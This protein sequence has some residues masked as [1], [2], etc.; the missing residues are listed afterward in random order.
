M[1]FD[2][3]SDYQQLRRRQAS[4]RRGARRSWPP[5]GSTCPRANRRTPRATGRCTAS[6]TA[7]TNCSSPGSG[8]R[9]SRSSRVRC[10]TWRPCRDR[11]RRWPWS[12]PARTPRTCSGSPAWSGS[13]TSGSTGS[14]PRPR[15]WPGKPAPDTFLAAAAR[16]GRRPDDAAVFEDASGRCRRRAGRWVRLRGRCR[17][18]RSRRGPGRGRGRSRGQRP[19]RAPGAVNEAAF[20]V[21]PWCLRET[22]L[23]LDRAGPD[24]V[25]VR[26]RQRPH[27]P[28]RQPRRGRAVR[29]ARA[30]TSTRSTSYGRCRTPR[31]ATATRSRA[32]P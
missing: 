1:P 3:A 4:R 12:P 32:R 16:L 15:A 17:P 7:R 13:S 8:P 6:A 21:E 14:W 25:G 24:R 29:L 26:P 2:L 18:G 5:G 9:A 31:P 30:P 11:A 23:D 20:S 19:R 22:G 28:A 27:R 10:A